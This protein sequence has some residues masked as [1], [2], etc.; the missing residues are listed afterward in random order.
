MSLQQSVVKL[1]QK[2]LPSPAFKSLIQEGDRMDRAALMARFKV[3][4]INDFDST[5]MD[6]M[7]TNLDKTDALGGTAKL[8]ELAR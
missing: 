5:F 3:L 2:T 4:S 6:A 1:L 7:K 8:V